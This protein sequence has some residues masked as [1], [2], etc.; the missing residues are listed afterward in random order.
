MEQGQITLDRQRTTEW[1][2]NAARFFLAA[3]LTA[4]QT[5]GGYAPFALGMVAAAGPGVPGVFAL[6]GAGTGALLFLNF[7]E[8]LPHIAVAILIVTAATSFREHP[9]LTRPDVLAWATAGLTL[10]VDGIYV[11]QSLAPLERATPCVIASVLAGVS[12]WVFRAVWLPAAGKETAD[13]WLFLA[14]ALAL[15]MVDLDQR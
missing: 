1:I 9:F 11:I 4:S 12:A 7:S 6:A 15:A 5:A 13:G 3:A 2:G 10:V 8:A 14:A